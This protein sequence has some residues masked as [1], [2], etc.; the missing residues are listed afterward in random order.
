MV[1]LAKAGVYKEFCAVNLLLM[2]YFISVQGLL[3]AI[4]AVT[5][6]RTILSSDGASRSIP[7]PTKP[8]ASSFRA[9]TRRVWQPTP[10]R[11][12]AEPKRR[13]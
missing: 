9:C 7:A 8:S 6:E 3:E 2:F 10:F 4:E 12:S 11:R 13:C 5:P 1:E